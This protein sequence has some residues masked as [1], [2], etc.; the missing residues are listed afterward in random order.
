MGL[1]W[2]TNPTEVTYSWYWALEKEGLSGGWGN[3]RA[4]QRTQ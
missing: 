1:P 4:E 2:P 3:G